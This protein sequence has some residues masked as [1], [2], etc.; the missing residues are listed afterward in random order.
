M[1]Q[2][3][4]VRDPQ[5]SLLASSRQLDN[6]TTV[7]AQNAL[8]LILGDL[9]VELPGVSPGRTILK[10]EGFSIS[11]SIKVKTAAFLLDSLEQRGVLVPGISTVIE[12]SSG[13][14][15]IAL[16][17]ICSMR[18]YRFICIT[19]PNISSTCVAAI[20]AYGGE[21]RAV[22]STDG[23]G[24]Y[25]GTRLG[26][27]KELIARHKDY[28]WPG[29]YSNQANSNAHELMTAREIIRNVPDVTH[30]YVGT[31]T[32]GTINGIARAFGRIAERVSIIAVEPT[33]SVTYGGP[34]APRRIPG[35]GTSVAPPLADPSL[36]HQ[37]IYVN[38]IDAIRECRRLVADHGLLLGGSSGSVVAAIRANAAKTDHRQV[39]VGISADNGDKYLDTIYNDHWVEQHYG[40]IPKLG[41]RR[42]S[43]CSQ[44]SR[45][46]DQYTSDSI[47]W[48]SEH[49]QH[50]Q[51]TAIHRPGL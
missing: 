41:E 13:N 49:A 18:G 9:F 47:E 35:I 51:T 4:G 30:V 36:P 50:K 22:Y 45:I 19:D 23:Q 10:L 6:L 32:T 20:Q 1:A 43:G 8:G 44:L 39:T 7:I 46:L 40:S 3:D 29:Q 26:L 37:V 17:L 21:I 33:G 25:L 16:S 2:H 15:G 27:V 24:G 42:G 31:G 12:S 38:E 48:D 34:P 5:R 14:L 28:V 11:G